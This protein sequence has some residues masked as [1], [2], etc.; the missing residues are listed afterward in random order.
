MIGFH[1]GRPAR[2]DVGLWLLLETLW[3]RRICTREPNTFPPS[4]AGLRGCSS[5]FIG[6]VGGTP[7]GT[8]P[9]VSL[10]RHTLALSG[11]APRFIELNK[12]MVSLL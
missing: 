8:A 9:E 3:C 4:T 7:G 2:P 6:E 5:C 11:F 12:A 10:C 1:A